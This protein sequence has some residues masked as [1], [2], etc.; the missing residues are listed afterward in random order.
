MTERQID[1]IVHMVADLDAAAATYEG[2]GFTLTP[3]AQHAWGTANRL[4]QFPDNS[5][6]EILEIDRP[7][8]I[9]EAESTQTPPRFSFGAY[10][11]DYL[12]DGEGL[13]M[14]VLSGNDS[15]GDAERFAEAGLGGYAPFDF[16]RQARQPDGSQV[17][18]GF[19]LAFATSEAMPRVACFTCHNRFP[20]NFWKPQY[21]QHANGAEGLAEVVM[22]S[23]E[24]DKQRQFFQSFTG[25]QPV[26]ED[27]G[28]VYRVGPHR[29]SIM[30]PQSYTTRFAQPAPSLEQGPR[31]A[32]LVVSGQNLASGIAPA[33]DAHG[34]MI[35]KRGS[36][37][38]A[39]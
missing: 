17:T 24:P 19:S 15:R 36:S 13:S 28:F 2:M 9:P 34:L 3:R 16:E 11:R 14:L 7:E 29:F 1:H 32:A 27:D 30:T 20:Q 23:A 10:N 31:F 37:A 18:V 4:V 33:A 35:A 12:K 26:A 39:A 8:L 22:V 21:Q 5:F 6:I 25:V 38:A